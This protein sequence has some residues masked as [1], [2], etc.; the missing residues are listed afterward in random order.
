MLFSDSFFTVSKQAEV[1]FK[2][3]GSK[4]YAFCYRLR[5]ESE[6][7]EKLLE[8]KKQHPSATHQCYAWRLG[9]D[10]QAFRVNDDGEPSGT[11]GKPIFGQIQAHNL[12]NVLI[13]VVRYFGGTQL[14][15]PGLIH[16][17]RTAAAE[18]IALA[19]IE[20]EFILFEYRA[21]FGMDDTSSVMRL[22]K[23]LDAKIIS[24]NYHENNILVFHVKKQNSDTLEERMKELYRVKL[25]FIT[26]V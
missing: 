24:N 16:A 25:K 9:P 22:L 13:V 1:L 26:L 7:K 3:R 11:A 17:Y 10:K 23:E 18:A 2:D 15:V 5:S 4:F 8:L 6:I 14:G 20:E 19:G 12:S 21:E